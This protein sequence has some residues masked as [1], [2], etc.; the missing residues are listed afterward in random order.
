V[1][2]VEAIMSVSYKVWVNLRLRLRNVLG[3]NQAQNNC[4]KIKNLVFLIKPT[5][6]GFFYF[7]EYL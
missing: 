2:N 5:I 7:Q 6:C 3:Y 1:K 4:R